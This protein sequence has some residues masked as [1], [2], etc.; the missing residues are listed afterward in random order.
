MEY[1]N[2]L[3]TVRMR[4]RMMAKKP[5]QKSMAFKDER[6]EIKTSLQKEWEKVHFVFREYNIE[7]CET[8][9][10]NKK[11]YQSTIICNQLDHY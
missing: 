10:Q 8:K 4:E 6:I 7:P 11:Y 5:N 9:A 3:M 1:P 2:R